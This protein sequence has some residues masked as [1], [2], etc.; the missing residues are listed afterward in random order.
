MW[1]IPLADVVFGT[2][3]A[4]AVT[5]VLE[6]G[7]LSMGPKVEQ[8]EKAFASL[9][10]APHAIAV[11]NGTAALHLACAALGLGPGDEVLVPSLTFVA[12]ANAIA[13]TGA[14]PVF[15]D[16]ASRDD[17]TICPDDCARRLTANTRAIM[18]M[19][20][21]GYPCDMDRIRSLARDNGLAVIEDAAHAPGAMYGAHSLGTLGVAGCFS[22]FSNKNMTTAEGGMV[23]TKD[24]A[25]AERMRTMRS[26]GMTTMTWDRHRGHASS[27][28]V[29]CHGF[30]YRLDEIRAALGLCQLRTLSDA[31]RVRGERTLQY[32]AGLAALRGV[33]VPFT[34]S[35]RGTPAYHLM[36]IAFAD[37]ATRDRVLAGLKERGIQSSI[38]YPPVHLF[39]VFLD[40]MGHVD[41]LG[42]TEDI[43]S[44]VLTLPLWGSM[45]ARHVD[46]VLAALESVLPG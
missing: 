46:E 41:G 1:K 25:L 33:T 45:T 11:S 37:R 34:S 15:V 17:W 13:Y 4:A 12:T 31:N 3:E 35:T 10:G 6:S 42:L 24:Q 28:D 8:F 5:A 2:E 44:R 27:Y 23:V 14:T 43:A 22:F 21:G 20:Y 32:R 40:R 26:H 16:V 7:W 38:H 30:N 29:V 9:T 18:V 39:S 19:H 36:P